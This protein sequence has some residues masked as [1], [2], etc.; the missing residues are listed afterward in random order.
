VNVSSPLNPYAS[1]AEPQRDRDEVG[2]PPIGDDAVAK[3]AHECRRTKGWLLALAVV[4]G[5]PA[6]CALVGVSLLAVA[7]GLF[8]CVLL[9]PT[10][11]VAWMVAELSRVRFAIKGF[12]RNP[13]VEYEIRVVDAYSRLFTSIIVL[14]MLATAAA[15][16]GLLWA[17]QTLSWFA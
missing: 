11:L 4:V 15:A 6:G 9:F 16:F 3:M 14:A 12:E 5:L 8:A 13:T 7:E 1:P 2:Q 17:F 10:L